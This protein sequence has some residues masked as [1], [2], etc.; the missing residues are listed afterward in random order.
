MA[1]DDSIQAVEAT[2]GHERAMAGAAAAIAD[3]EQRRRWRLAEEVGELEAEEQAAGGG[4]QDVDGGWT[5]SGASTP[6]ASPGAAGR[7]RNASRRRAWDRGRA[8]GLRGRRGGGRA[9]RRDRGCRGAW[10]DVFLLLRPR[11]AVTHEARERADLLARAGLRPDAGPRE[12]AE[13]RDELAVARARLELSGAAKA[14]MIARRAELDRSEREVAAATEATTAAEGAWHAWLRDAASRTTRRPRR[15]DSCFGAAGVARRRGRGSRSS[16][17]GAQGAGTAGRGGDERADTLFTSLGPRRVRPRRPIVALGARLDRALD[18]ERRAS[19]LARARAQLAIRR[20]PALEL[21]EEREAAVDGH[22]VAIGCPGSRSAPPARTCIR[23][24]KGAARGGARTPAA[25]GNDRP[26]KCM[27]TRSWPRHAR[28]IPQ[29]STSPRSRR[30]PSSSG[31]RQRSATRP[32]DRALEALMHRLE[33]A[34]DVG[35][36]RQELAMLEGRAAA[37]A[38]EWAVGALALRLLEETRSR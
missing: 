35:A 29:P 17:R 23:R 8:A 22:L 33:A 34:D 19:E 38:R 3:A 28:P 10:R 13:A 7:A 37:M 16:A 31:S 4:E 6:R 15:R 30:A 25:P 11:P 9:G 36:R 26:G 20:R 21:V 24:A 1:L 2:R 32:P 18:A 5:R 14:R 12:I 27:S